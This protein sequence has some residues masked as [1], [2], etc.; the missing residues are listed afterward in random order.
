MNIFKK[1]YEFNLILIK[2]FIRVSFLVISGGIITLLTLAVVYLNHQPNL[3]IWHTTK[4]DTEFTKNTPVK[5][6]ADY[7][8]VEERLFAQLKERVYDRIKEIGRAHV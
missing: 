7:L 5:N 3:K 4:L 6:F 8:A 2:N 1:I